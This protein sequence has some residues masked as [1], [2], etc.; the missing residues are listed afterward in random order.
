MRAHTGMMIYFSILRMK[1]AS[2]LLHAAKQA[3]ATGTH[4]KST[5][6]KTYSAALK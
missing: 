2:P 6:D 4:G 1:T 5:T 3:N